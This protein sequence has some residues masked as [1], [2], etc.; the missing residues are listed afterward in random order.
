MNQ[1]SGPGSHEIM[2]L[3]TP[4]YGRLKYDFAS[5]FTSR[6]RG[7]ETNDVPF[8]LR[9]RMEFGRAAASAQQKWY[10]ASHVWMTIPL[11]PIASSM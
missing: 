3:S 4:L 2:D 1:K 11:R 8:A 5:F 7:L 9:R 10:C 6:Y